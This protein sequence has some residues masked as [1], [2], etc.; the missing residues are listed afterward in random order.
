MSL[1]L[2]LIEQEMTVFDARDVTDFH[3]LQEIL[4]YCL[5]YPASTKGRRDLCSHGVT[6][7]KIGARHCRSDRCP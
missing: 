5:D 2:D 1:I 3:L 7:A 4:D 6:E